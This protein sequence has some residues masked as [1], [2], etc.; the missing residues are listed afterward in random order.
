LQKLAGLYDLYSYVRRTEPASFARTAYLDDL[1]GRMRD[2]S[3]QARFDS[4]EVATWF[5]EGSDVLRVIALNVMLAR[6]ECR[7]FMAVLKAVGQPRSLFEQFYGLLLGREMLPGLEVLERGLLAEA[8]HRARR[9]RRFRADAP[10]MGL[11]GEIL[12][13]MQAFED[14]LV[15]TAQPVR[16]RSDS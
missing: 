2:A 15:K 14:S 8:I 7:D 1:A 11:S 6:E 9:K 3:E 12:D 13:Q 4:A 5:R 10:L 16:S